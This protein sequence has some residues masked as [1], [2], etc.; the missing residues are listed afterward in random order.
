MKLHKLLKSV[1]KGTPVRRD[2]WG[3]GCF[4]YEKD[5]KFFTQS[6]NPINPSNSTR[7]ENDWDTVESLM[8]H[9]ERVV[10]F[11]KKVLLGLKRNLEKLHRGNHE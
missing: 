1:P 7:Q 8:T 5:G 4:I 6:G 3:K 11:H 9:F 2:A 10:D